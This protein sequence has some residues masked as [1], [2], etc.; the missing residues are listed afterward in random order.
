MELVER[1]HGHLGDVVG[2]LG[3][4]L[5]GLQVA[6]VVGDQS[7][8]VLEVDLFDRL[9]RLGDDRRLP[10]RGLDVHGGDGHAGL[11]GVV[12]TELLD[13][14]D[15]DRGAPRAVELVALLDDLGELALVH[16]L[17]PE[18]HRGEVALGRD[19]TDG[20]HGVEDEPPHRGHHQ[21]GAGGFLLTLAA[22][23]QQL[24]G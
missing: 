9:I 3:P 24:S 18:D 14:V 10:G 11:G 23:H 13:A 15:D 20:Q 17:V 19:V 2:R 1:R 16:G 8:P 22:G 12:E 4:D 6:L 5:D 7:A 21:L